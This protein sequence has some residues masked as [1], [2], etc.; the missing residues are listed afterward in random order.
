[1]AWNAPARQRA[2]QRGG[3]RAARAVRGA[4]AVNPHPAQLADRP[5]QALRRRVEQVHAAVAQQLRH[6]AWLN[7]LRQYLQLLAGEAEVVGI[8]LDAAST[9]LVQ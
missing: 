3:G 5:I 2:P 8:D 1:M 9:P 6:Q 7:A 4:Q